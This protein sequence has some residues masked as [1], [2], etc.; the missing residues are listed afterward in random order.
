MSTEQGVSIKDYN[1]L[2]EAV[3][4]M[5]ETIQSMKKK[6]EEMDQQL[7]ILQYNFTIGKKHIEIIQG[8]LNKNK[9]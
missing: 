6:Q 8:K 4:T 1:R 3:L 7:A 9:K 5:D 2:I